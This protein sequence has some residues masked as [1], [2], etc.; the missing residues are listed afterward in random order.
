[1]ENFIDVCIIM[2]MFMPLPLQLCTSIFM[3]TVPTTGT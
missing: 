3:F 2:N 1:M